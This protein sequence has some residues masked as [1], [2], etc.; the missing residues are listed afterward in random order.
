LKEIESSFNQ[1]SEAASNSVVFEELK[2][3]ELKKLFHDFSYRAFSAAKVLP[4][5][6]KEMASVFHFPVG[7]S[8]VNHNSKKLK[9][10]SL[11]RHLR[12]EMRV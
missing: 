11:L 2:G 5:N 8:S 10:A 9:L 7:I 12:W 3:S 6:L 4:M 1:F